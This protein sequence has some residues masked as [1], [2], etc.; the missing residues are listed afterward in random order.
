MH[1]INEALD[2]LISA[3][4]GDDRIRLKEAVAAYREHNDYAPL[5]AALTPLADAGNGEALF[6]LGACHLYGRGMAQDEERATACWEKAAAQGVALAQTMLGALYASQGRKAEAQSLFE[7]AAAQGDNY[8]PSALHMLDQMKAPSPAVQRALR[9][10]QSGDGEGARRK[11]EE[12]AANGDLDAIRHLAVM[13]QLGAGVPQNYEIA[14]E[15]WLV[16]LELG[17]DAAQYALGELYFNGTG[18]KTDYA[19]ARDYWEQAAAQGNAD[20]QYGLGVIY[21]D[22]HGVAEDEE[23][24]L[25][26]FKKA[27]AQGHPAAQTTLGDYHAMTGDLAAAVGLWRLAALQQYPPAQVTLGEHYLQEENYAE[28]RQWLRLAA[29][30]GN[31]D[32]QYLLGLSYIIADDADEHL[33]D[34]HTLWHQAADQGHPGA[35]EALKKLHG[36]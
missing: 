21:R 3:Q 7:K 16:A 23:T 12:H 5:I 29:D 1:P 30:A 33:D 15:W 17:D 31:A 35:Q 6:I 9:I 4:S 8:A 11:L 34:I 32:G 22:G 10:L 27:V 2:R 25:A 13:F 36:E 14:R 28:A 20:A 26:W 18:V 19:R 24:A